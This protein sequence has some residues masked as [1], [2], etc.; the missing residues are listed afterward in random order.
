MVHQSAFAFFDRIT[1]EGGLR[2]PGDQ[3]SFTPTSVF[4]LFK[5]EKTFEQTLF[6][7]ILRT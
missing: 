2:D 6:K 3:V 4:L 5:I 1:G 7:I